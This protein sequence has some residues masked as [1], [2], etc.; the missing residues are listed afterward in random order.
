MKITNHYLSWEGGG[1]NRHNHISI[2]DE[3]HTNLVKSKCARRVITDPSRSWVLDVRKIRTQ[4]A[5]NFFGKNNEHDDCGKAIDVEVEE[6]MERH[7]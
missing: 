6:A 7:L 2:D 3:T 1:S 5:P 4:T